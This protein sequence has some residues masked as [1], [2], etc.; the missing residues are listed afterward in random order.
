MSIAARFN[1]WC[2]RTIELTPLLCPDT[3]KNKRCTKEIEALLNQWYG[4]SA[5]PSEI[6]RYNPVPVS[7]A[8]VVESVAAKVIPPW[9]LKISEV[10][11]NWENVAGKENARRCKPVSLNDHV[12]Y[13]EV[14]HPMYRMVLDTPKIKQ[15]L[16]ERIQQITGKDLCQELK[17]P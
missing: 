3:M 15:Q 7:L 4:K 9:E 16:L 17:F 12:L 13:I 6:N 10:K 1:L 5:A 11:E 14:M 8:N 2:R